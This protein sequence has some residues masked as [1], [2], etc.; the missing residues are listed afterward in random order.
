MNDETI[1][2]IKSGHLTKFFIMKI[3]INVKRLLQNAYMG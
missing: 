3:H 1:K 2:F